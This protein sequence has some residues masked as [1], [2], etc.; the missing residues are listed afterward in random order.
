[1]KPYAT[2]ALSL[3]LSLTLMTGF[4]QVNN[5]KPKQFNSFPDVINC[6]EQELTKI[7]NASPGQSISIACSNNFTFAGNITSNLSKYANLQS[8]VVVSPDF[9]N[10]IFSISKITNGDGSVAYVGRIINKNYGDG[11]E[12]K[13]NAT[14]DY[15][16][17]KVETDY[18][19]PDC[20]LQ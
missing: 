7:F 14:G 9:L 17:K 15:L 13:K 19:M 12:L 3:V 8:A 11:F 5:P 10:T 20:L 16:L 1:M 2:Y 4:G 18:V 6:S